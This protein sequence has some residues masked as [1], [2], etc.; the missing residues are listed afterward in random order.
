MPKSKLIRLTNEEL[1]P[2]IE[3]LNKHFEQLGT[4]IRAEPTEFSDCSFTLFIDDPLVNKHS[5]FYPV[6]TF[7]NEIEEFIKSINYDYRLV[8]NNT[9]LIIGIFTV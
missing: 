1:Q 5:S 9:G 7:R 2:V 8:F 6:E 4:V 3:H